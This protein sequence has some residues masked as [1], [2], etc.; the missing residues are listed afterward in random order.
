MEVINVSESI[1]F[2]DI[3]AAD[4]NK[5]S[6]FTSFKA[7][8]INETNFARFASFTLESMVI[9]NSFITKNIATQ[10]ATDLVAAVN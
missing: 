2:T 10:I 5:W 4:T 7:V 8:I 6:Y 1:E 3:T 9:N